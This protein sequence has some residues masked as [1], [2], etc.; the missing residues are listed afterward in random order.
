MTEHDRIAVVTGAAS[1]IGAATARRLARD[2]TTVLVCDV[3]DDTG[4]AVARDVGGAYVHLDVGGP[5]SWDGLV[6]RLAGSRVTGA[7]LNAGVLTA[8][9]PTPF[10]DVPVERLARV[11]AVNLDG[12]LLGVRALAP[13]MAAAGGG[14][15]VATSSLAGLGPY[16]ADP[17]YA[18]TKHG[19]VG[20]VRS[21]APQLAA[22]GVRLH[23]IC[24][25]GVDTGLLAADRKAEIVAAGRPM[26]DPAEV[27]DAVAALLGRDDAGVIATIV[28]GRGAQPYEFRG[29]PGPRA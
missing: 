16:E 3:A 2:G 28:A 7:L 19:I 21:V 18:A 25:G 5:G 10:L 9:E 12:V 27:A 26:L 23:A 14:A 13:L 11:R 8:A 22:R 15:I 4:E 1:G 20:F 17:M 29:V 6:Q 24:P